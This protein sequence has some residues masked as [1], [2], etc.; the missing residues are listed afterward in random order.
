MLWKPSGSGALEAQSAAFE[1]RDGSLVIQ[2]PFQCPNVDWLEAGFSR[3]I[4]EARD[5]K[6]APRAFA[7]EGVLPFCRP[8]RSLSLWIGGG[9]AGA[10]V[11][12][13]VGLLLWS[14]SF[15][16]RLGTFWRRKSPESIPP[17]W[18]KD[19]LES[20]GKQL[21]NVV[22]A[23]SNLRLATSDSTTASPKPEYL[24]EHGQGEDARPMPSRTSARSEVEGPE[25]ALL[26]IVNDWWAEGPGD[27]E[28]LVRRVRESGFK[29]YVSFDTDGTLRRM[30][31][32]TYAFRVSNGPAGWLWHPISQ[33]E[34][35]AVPADPFLFHAGN[36]IEYVR[37]FF[38]G[39]GEVPQRFRF[40]RAY[41]ACRLKAS[42]TGD[43][44][45]LV[46][47]GYLELADRTGARVE[48]PNS[49]S[50][51]SLPPREPERSTERSEGALERASSSKEIEKLFRF[52]LREELRD[53]R[54]LRDEA[55]RGTVLSSQFERALSRLDDLPEILQRLE[56]IQL[57]IGDL[58]GRG[59]RIEGFPTDAAVTH[60]EEGVAAAD[61]EALEA[62]PSVQPASPA[63]GH[64]EDA[65][66]EPET[67]R[68][69]FAPA[70]SWAEPASRIASEPPE[71]FLRRLLRGLPALA[72]TAAPS[73]AG[74]PNPAEYLRRLAELGDRLLREQAGRG[75]RVDLV[76]LVI[77]QADGE[78]LFAAH[79][80]ENVG[81]DY[82]TAKCPRCGDN[83]MGALLFQI[84]LAVRDGEG[85]LMAIAMVRSNLADR[86]PDG[87][88]LLTGKEYPRSDRG[89][90]RM[91]RPAVLQRLQ[92]GAGDLYKVVLTMDVVF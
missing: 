36:M 55:P 64:A 19:D 86:Y 56:G 69:R 10:F 6:R 35:L 22:E 81:P 17:E 59:E 61:E 20:L 74:N 40:Y 49:P 29:L 37:F 76:H 45:H 27:K 57:S 66:V 46:E 11:L 31:G 90:V 28:D 77:R 9:A 12:T 43:R 25:K 87:Y 39:I 54:Q 78:R 32:R 3:V 72:D 26:Q 68:D 62:L 65:P 33:N 34:A 23:V 91:S 79:V 80:I 16:T 70:S 30:V 47:K 83:L 60:Q 48:G 2:V 67:P 41:R 7:F 58:A 14:P 24:P 8:R 5:Q 89:S 18:L 38:D 84:F 71:E 75:W 52:A 73:G 4:F 13:L 1:V 50:R 15:R 82:G 85:D 51:S 92:S 63:F 42:G 21:G 53:L 44:Y 88:A